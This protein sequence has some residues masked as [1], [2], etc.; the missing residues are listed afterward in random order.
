MGIWERKGK[1]GQ[2]TFYITYY[3]DGKKGKYKRQKLPP[4]TT[5]EQAEVMDAGFS[6]AH[7]AQHSQLAEPT[8]STIKELY[9]QYVQHKSLYT[10]SEGTRKDIETAGAHITRIL[11]KT[12]VRHL[13][14][15]YVDLYIASRQAEITKK[16]TPIKNRTINKEL[17]W[18]SG[19]LEWCRKKA[20]I[21]LPVIRIESLPSNRPLPIILSMEEI[22]AILKVAKPLQRAYISLLYFSGLRRDEVNQ[23]EWEHVSIIID[24]N[25]QERSFV[26]VTGKGHR[27]RLEPVPLVA[28]AFL[29]EIRP[30]DPKGYIF[31]NKKTDKPYKRLNRSLSNYAQKAGITKRVTPHLL[32]HSF[33]THALEAGADLRAIQTLLGHKEISTTEWYTHV[34]MGHKY[35]ASDA[36]MAAYERANNGVRQA[37]KYPKYRLVERICEQCGKPFKVSQTD[38]DRGKGRVCSLECRREKLKNRVDM[39]CLFCG[40]IHKVKASEIGKGRKFCNLS[41]R[42]GYEEQNRR[43]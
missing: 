34:A 24:E 6:T 25:G 32:R 38:I 13:N 42:R 2:V 37:G 31:F 9:P 30:N 33:A 15:A 16:G 18:F 3:P 39:V 20:K 14:D 19:F 4:G 5:R 17:S 8:G 23:I 28:L 35:V 36:L 21:N 26:K 27:E 22:T 43:K 10:E 1:N 12:E 11:G 40:K 7:K 29:S 41:C